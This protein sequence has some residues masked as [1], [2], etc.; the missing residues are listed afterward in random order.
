LR[1]AL[2]LSLDYPMHEPTNSTP[3]TRWIAHA[4]ILSA[5]DLRAIK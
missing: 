2:L 3:K 5:Q 4:K 1:I